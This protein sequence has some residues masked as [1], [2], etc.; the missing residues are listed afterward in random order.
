MDAEAR[1]DEVLTAALE[2]RYVAPRAII[3]QPRPTTTEDV[4]EI[5]K[6]ASLVSSLPFSLRQWRIPSPVYWAQ[7]LDAA[8][9]RVDDD[10]RWE[11]EGE[12]QLRIREAVS[13]LIEIEAAYNQS[14]GPKETPTQIYLWRLTGVV[15]HCASDQVVV[16]R[17][18]T[19]VRALQRELVRANQC[20][21]MPLE[22]DGRICLGRGSLTMSIADAIGLNLPHALEAQCGNWRDWILGMTVVLT[23]GTVVKSGSRA[24]KNVA[25][26]DAHK[27]FVGARSTLGIIVEVTLKTFPLA[28][29]PPHEGVSFCGEPIRARERA[30][31]RRKPLWIQ[32]T[33]R[34]DFAAAVRAAGSS[35]LE[36][37]VASSTL[38]A[39]IPK[40]RELPR[41]EGDHVIR[42]GCGEKNIQITDPTL[43]RLMQQAKGI[44]DPTN[45][46]NPGELGVV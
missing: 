17:A 11:D 18:G 19:R 4:S 9:C 10:Q 20:L 34:S 40:E 29:L 1:Y 2:R 31:L 44:F 39:E 13:R 6:G 8:L 38:W 30:Q 5:V 12:R 23:D 16:V 15:E 24:V 28:S 37:D 36:S 43:A 22:D 26:F 32:R 45:K 21:P 42:K 3:S 41:F 33:Q 46:L 35:L 27:L 7:E 25:G 14:S